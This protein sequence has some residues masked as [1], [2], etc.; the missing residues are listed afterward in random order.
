MIKVIILKDS[1]GD[2]TGFQIAG[3]A[4]YADSGKDIICAAVSMLSLNII[5]SVEV[6]TD[7]KFKAEQDDAHGILKFKFT[8][9]VSKES[10]VLFDSLVLGLTEIENT[11][12][13]QYIRILFKEV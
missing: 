13:G 3:H 7:D 12:G 1:Q 5:N 10:K 2:Y 8:G 9:P 6:L 11:Y 4:G